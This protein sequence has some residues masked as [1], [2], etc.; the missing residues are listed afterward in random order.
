[1]SDGVKRYRLVRGFE[2]VRQNLGK[3]HHISGTMRPWI[4]Q[5]G[6][7]SGTGISALYAVRPNP[8]APRPGAA[9]SSRAG[10]QAVASQPQPLD[11]GKL[12][13]RPLSRGAIRER[14]SAVASRDRPVAGSAGDRAQRTAVRCPGSVIARPRYGRVG[15]AVCGGRF[16][17]RVPDG[18]AVYGAI[19]RW[20]VCGAVGLGTGRAGTTTSDGDHA[21]QTDNRYARLHG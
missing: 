3:C 17:D 5:S 1:M 9:S 2:P 7:T 6:L 13:A 16:T 10:E 19:V 18:W 14:A 15:V 12:A 20:A 8:P 4:G 11:T 21:R